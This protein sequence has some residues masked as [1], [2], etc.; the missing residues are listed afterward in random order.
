MG[1]IV[2]W[3][4]GIGKESRNRPGGADKDEVGFQ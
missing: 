1:G 4:G 3:P 2:G